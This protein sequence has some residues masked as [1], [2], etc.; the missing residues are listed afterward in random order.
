MIKLFIICLLL[1]NGILSSQTL[2]DLHILKHGKYEMTEWSS[3][4]PAKTYPKSMIFHQTNKIDPKYEDEMDSDWIYPYNLTSKSRI[5]GNDTLGFSFLNTSLSQ[6]DGGYLGAAVIGLNTIDCSEIQFNCTC[7]TIEPNSRIYAIKAQYKIG[8]D[9][10]KKLGLNYIM[11]S[12]ENHYSKYQLYLPE[13]CNNQDSVYIRWKYFFYENDEG[14]RAELGIDDILIKAMK[15]TGIN[16]KSD[17]KYKIIDNSIEIYSPF[18]CKPEIKIYNLIGK[19]YT[20]FNYIVNNN[21]FVKIDLNNLNKGF[22]L[23]KFN[24]KNHSKTIKYIK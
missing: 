24:C 15:I 4:Q 14:A 6:E 11:S 17:F 16:E 23:I 13:E 7:R 2:P 19:E 22:Y 12:I 9:E 5:N 8:N 20:N 18:N 1:F 21:G 3:D 10:Y